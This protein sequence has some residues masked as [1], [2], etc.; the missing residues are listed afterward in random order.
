M[1]IYNGKI[2]LYCF[3]ASLITSLLLLLPRITPS[4]KCIIDRVLWVVPSY[5]VVINVFLLL[6]FR[7]YALQVINVTKREH[8]GFISNVKSKIDL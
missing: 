3:L 7:G 1:L 8:F 4:G 2:S 6:C 5:Y